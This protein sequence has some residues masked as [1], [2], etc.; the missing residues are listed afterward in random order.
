MIFVVG[1]RKKGLR[2][3]QQMRCDA[4]PLVPDLALLGGGDLPSHAWPCQA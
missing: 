1:N 4:M 3:A 2:V